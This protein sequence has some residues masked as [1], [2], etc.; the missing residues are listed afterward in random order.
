MVQNTTNVVNATEL[1]TE[2]MVKV[3]NFTLG[4]FCHN[5]KKKQGNMIGFS[6]FKK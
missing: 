3:F 5:K 6:K 2:K 4:I 1:Y